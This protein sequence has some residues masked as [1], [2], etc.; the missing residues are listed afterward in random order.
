M[1]GKVYIL[2]DDQEVL[3]NNISDYIDTIQV[4]GTLYDPARRYLERIRNRA[5]YDTD[6]Q[7]ILNGWRRNYIEYLAG[8]PEELTIN[9]QLPSKVKYVD[10]KLVYV[11]QQE[12]NSLSTIDSDTIYNII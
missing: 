3:I 2:T 11:T 8:K 5:T 9:V 6:E 7:K 12:Y 1:S 10:I 4:P